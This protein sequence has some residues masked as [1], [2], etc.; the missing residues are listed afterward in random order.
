MGVLRKQGVLDNPERMGR[1]KLVQCSEHAMDTL[2][3]PVPALAHQCFGDKCSFS[4]C[5]C[6]T[7]SLGR[8][9][10][11]FAV[12]G[13]KSTFHL[14]GN[15]G[16]SRREYPPALSCI[17]CSRAGLP[18]L[19]AQGHRAELLLLPGGH[20]PQSDPGTPCQQQ[21]PCPSREGCPRAGGRAGLRQGCASPV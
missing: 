3:V 18:P 15:A 9:E 8:K 7:G 16:M 19:P 10:E 11:P 2:P 4:C 1:K 6:C 21:P 20:P 12:P 13:R 5:C 14:Q 17:P